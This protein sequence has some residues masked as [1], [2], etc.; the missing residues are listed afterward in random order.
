MTTIDLNSAVRDIKRLYVVTF[1]LDIAIAL[2]GLATV[3]VLISGHP[4]DSLKFLA[5]VGVLMTISYFV[6]RRSI[7]AW[8]VA[9]PVILEGPA[10]EVHG[11]VDDVA[12]KLF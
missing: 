6:R 5:V 1:V 4:V 9:R 12:Q 11:L 7:L 8:S 3:M 2:L 10:S